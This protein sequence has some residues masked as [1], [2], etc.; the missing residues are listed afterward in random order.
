MDP[1]ATYADIQQK[2][3]L[4]MPDVRIGVLDLVGAGLLEKQGYAGGD[5]LIWPKSDLF[6]TFDAEF[7]DWDP[8]KDARDLAVHLLNLD[9]DQA[10]A[11]EVAHALGW[12]PR[13]FNAAAAYLVSARIVK[14][15]EYMGGDE[16]WPCGFL[17][18]D[19]LLRFIRSI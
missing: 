11:S 17:I 19:E 6:A 1:Q 9:T 2:S 5:S 3:G 15:N 18:G 14:P 7:M 10:Y 12:P 4:A 8:E 13:R 16:Y